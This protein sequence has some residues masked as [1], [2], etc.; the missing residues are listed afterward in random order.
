MVVTVE[1]TLQYRPTGGFVAT[2]AE[3]AVSAAGAW[4]A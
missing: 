2:F 1:T 4:I 3:L